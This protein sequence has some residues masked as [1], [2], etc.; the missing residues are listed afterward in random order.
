MDSKVISIPFVL[1]DNS[2]RIAYVLHMLFFF[3]KSLLL[4][5]KHFCSYYISKLN[6]SQTAVMNYVIFRFNT[7]TGVLKAVEW[8]HLQVLVKKKET[9]P[10]EEPPCLKGSNNS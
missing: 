7:F 2:D 3:F 9:L 5:P 1:N 4:R 8:T 6:I 10:D